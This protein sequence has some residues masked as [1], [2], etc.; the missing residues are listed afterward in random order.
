MLG[1]IFRLTGKYTSL[2]WMLLTL[3]CYLVVGNFSVFL[4]PSPQQ[5]T[6]RGHLHW[7]W[8]WARVLGQSGKFG[9]EQGTSKDTPSQQTRDEFHQWG[10]A[11]V[12]GRWTE[13]KATWEGVQAPPGLPASVSPWKVRNS[14]REAEAGVWLTSSGVKYDSGSVTHQLG[15][16]NKWPS[17]GLSSVKLIIAT[18]HVDVN[19]RIEWENLLV[20]NVLHGSYL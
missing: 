3:W 19:V 7:A 13:G 2:P 12:R 5:Q 4:P 11:P 9:D 8:S 18:N 16:W 10:T 17:L 15:H 14:S 20:I 6:W 1:P